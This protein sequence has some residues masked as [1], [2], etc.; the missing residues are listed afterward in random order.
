MPRLPRVAIVGAGI[1]GL[2]AARALYACGFD[3]RV[4]EQARR[5]VRLGAGIQQSPNAVRVLRGLGLE[6]AL[7]ATGFAPRDF[8]HR[9]AETGELTNAI[10]LGEAAEQRYGAPYLT[11]HRGDLH[12]VLL[13]GLPS[14]AVRRDARLV[15]LDQAGERVVLSFADGSR[16]RADVVVGADGVHSTVREL[17]VGTDELRFSGRVGYRATLRPEEAS[18]PDDDN[19]KWWGPDRHLITYYITA[20]RD[21]IYA[22]GTVPEPDFDLESW[23]ARGDVEQ[24]RAHFASFHP[25]VGRLLGRVDEVHTWALADRAPLPQWSDGSVVL[26]GD[27]AHPMMPHMGQGAAMAIE[28][29]AVLA[30]CLEEATTG[31]PAALCRFEATRRQRTTQMQAI[32][33]GNT[34]ARSPAETVDWVYGYDAWSVPLA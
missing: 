22:M 32:S 17:L 27:A 6:P 12:D 8:L 15:G 20:G 19:T 1:G 25:V 30:R 31:W 21:E 24:L 28:D 29:A 5:F 14:R 4:Y 13:G 11:M 2:A 3:I 33:A 34:F 23:S 18:E 10:P 26:L 7:R 9:M 16:D